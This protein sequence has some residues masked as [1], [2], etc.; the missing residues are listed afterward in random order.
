MAEA[1]TGMRVPLRVVVQ[2][3]AVDEL[4][5]KVAFALGS[6]SE[7]LDRVPDVVR[8]RGVHGEV[9]VVPARTP[10]GRGSDGS[11]RASCPAWRRGARQHLGF[12]R[13]QRSGDGIGVPLRRA[14]SSTSRPSRSRSLDGA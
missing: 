12:S 7:Q 13:V 10:R 1:E 2:E 5:A 9:A 6:H 14:S 4:G 3:V 8:H 11:V